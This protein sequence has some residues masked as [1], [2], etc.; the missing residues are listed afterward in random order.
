MAIEFRLIMAKKFVALHV[1]ANP[2]NRHKPKLQLDP[3]SKSKFLSFPFG[4]RAKPPLS[5]VAIDLSA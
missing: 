4:V 5:R 3:F 2:D 1:E